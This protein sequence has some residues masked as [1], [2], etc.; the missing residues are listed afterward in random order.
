[1]RARAFLIAGLLSAASFAG[2]G[3]HVDAPD[4]AAESF[5]LYSID[6]YEDPKNKSL[7]SFHGYPVL[8]KRSVKDT[9]TR[10][11]LVA[12]FEDG[13]SR[14]DG[15][16]YTCFWPRHAIRTV[17][18]GKTTD[19]LICFECHQYQVFIG[20]EFPPYKTIDGA[21]LAKFNAILRRTGL[22]LA[23]TEPPDFK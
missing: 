20:E 23:P 3:R 9:K 12:A 10:E 8:G 7:E 15:E 17:R 4:A 16:G 1:M 18:G 22:P 2:C 14:S 21:P 19:Y 11:E 5:I 13:V 6:G